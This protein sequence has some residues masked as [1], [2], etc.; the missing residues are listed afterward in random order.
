MTLTEG[1]GKQKR[2]ME[3]D[4]E[5]LVER[6]WELS[7]KFDDFEASSP[8]AAMKKFLDKLRQYLD[9]VSIQD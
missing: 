8:K 2:R 9:R 1:T 7:D 6:T 3:S 4:E 5:V